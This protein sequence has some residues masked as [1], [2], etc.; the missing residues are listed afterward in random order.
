MGSSDIEIF[1][2]TNRHNDL[3]V[4]AGWA[5]HDKWEH[6][7]PQTGFEDRDKELE[8]YLDKII[9]ARLTTVYSNQGR[10]AFNDNGAF[11]VFQRGTSV[12]GYTTNVYLADRWVHNLAALGTFTMSQ[13][14]DAPA[15]T[16]LSHSLKLL[17]TTA[18]AAPAAADQSN[19]QH[20]I[21][22]QNLQRLMWGTPAALPVT[23]SF[24]VKSNQVGNYMFELYRNEGTIRT[25][26]A[27]YTINVASTWEYKT[28]T[29]P[30]DQTG[31]IT[32]DST[33]RLY[34]I[35]W[36]GGGT[37]YTG[38]AALQTSWANK[39]DNLRAVGQTNLAV[40][41]NNF[42]QFAGIQV[43]AGSVATPFEMR[44]YGL[45]LSEAKRYFERFD[46]LTGVFTY[47]V[48]AAFNISA[49]QSLGLLRFEVT[50]RAVPT[51][52]F[53]AANTF[54]VYNGAIAITACTA[55][56]TDNISPFGADLFT[57]VAGGPLG[58]TGGTAIFS[59]N[60][61]AATIDISADI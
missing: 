47:F 22:G 31:A 17:C 11:N 4:G 40:T 57:T 53:S 38:G 56:T 24:W 30:G 12:A 5:P 60:T 1:R 10:R 35:W 50:K 54:A 44:P 28:V 45:E 43:E 59:N 49:T 8:D 33:G 29:F 55:I 41:I 61:T 2:Y 13:Q 19:L 23:V 16:G 39:T 21:E 42:V 52:A 46:S 48:S 26:S 32:N 36:L 58:V 51:L 6:H 3:D 27:K 14:A 34:G 7:Y 18:D 37:N 20:G 9:R 15:N 25:I